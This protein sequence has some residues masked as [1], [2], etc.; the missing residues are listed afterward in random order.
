MVHNGADAV[1]LQSSVTTARATEQIVDFGFRL[2]QRGR[3]RLTPCHKTNIL[4]HAGRVWE[5]VVERIGA[6]YPGVEVDYVHVDAM[7]MHLPTTPAPPSGTG[8]SVG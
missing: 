8:S 5:G 1:A 2:A 6:R 4:V 7:C 3:G